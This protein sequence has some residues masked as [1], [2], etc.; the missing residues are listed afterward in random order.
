MATIA[1]I[2]V[3]LQAQTQGFVRDIQNAKKRLESF[4]NTAK[5]IGGKMSAGVSLPLAG[6]GAA[7]FKASYDF[8]KSMNAVNALSGSTAQEFKKLEEQALALGS[9]T[10]YSAIEISQGMQE[11]SKSG[12]EATETMAALPGMLSLAAASGIELGEAAGISSDLLAAFQLDASKAGYAADVLAA[13]TTSANVDMQSLA[14][15]MGEVAGT[16]NSLGIDIAETSAYLAKFSDQNIKGSKGGTTL[17]N[18]LIDMTKN[19]EKMNNVFG[20]PV[21][22]KKTGEMRNFTAIMAD[23]EKA[24]GEMTQEQRQFALS[25]VFG[26]EAMRGVNA[27][28][29]TGTDTL[30]EYTNQLRN[31]DGAAKE[32]AD[33]M[34]SGVVK[35]MNDMKAAVE[36]ASIALGNTLIP[37]IAPV[38]EKVS[39]LAQWFSKL[40]PPIRNTITAVALTVVAI[41]PLV[42][43]AGLLAGSLSSLIGI[44]PTLGTVFAALTGPVGIAISVIGGVA[45]AITSL[46]KHNEQFRKNVTKI[47]SNIK[48]SALEIFGFLKEFWLAWGQE[49]SAV[50][51]GMW[52]Q[53]KNVVQFAMTFIGNTI[54]LI[55]NVI[56]GDWSGAWENIKSIGQAAWTFISTSI[57]NF[58]NTWKTIFSDTW[59]KIKA[60]VIEIWENIKKWLTDVTVK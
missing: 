49:I 52:A 28:M 4:G 29:S 39:Q 14:Y 20:I 18:V 41:G 58:T 16:A 11:L 23:L 25:Q 54:G 6:I 42:G 34:N 9:S 5:D 21:F 57:A 30:K 36:G 24:T 35:T 31:S 12:F 22:D 19:A 10:Q 46:W 43:I 44:L 37:V 27:I 48:Q 17:N 47:W 45:V 8:K 51:I 7:A 13:A 40:N 53:I 2:A 59:A 56:T 32:I 50:F 38:L 15:G 1:G 60:N 33:K 26:V 3:Q 55:L